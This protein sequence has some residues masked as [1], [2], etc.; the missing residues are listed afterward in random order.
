MRALISLVFALALTGSADAAARFWVGGTGTWDASDTTHWAASSGGA[1]GQSVPGS[2]DTV[3]FDGS[4]GG[5][6]VT[7]NH[8]SNTIQ[9]LTFGAFTGTLD[10]ATND[11]NITLTAGTGVSGTGTGARTLNMGDGTWTL[12]AT[13]AAWDFSTTTNL[14]FNANGSTIAYTSTAA[15]A[16]TFLSGGLTYNAVTVAGAASPGP[17]GINSSGNFTIGSLTINGPQAWGFGNTTT[18]TV[19]T[20]TVNASSASTLVSFLVTPFGSTTLT[21]TNAPT[22]AWCAFR[23]ITA[24]GGFSGIT[25]TDSQNLGGNTSFSITPPSSGGGGGSHVIGG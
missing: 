7:V 10:F 11:N 15:N 6:T 9:S 5:G 12:S 1:G 20:L 13:G 8:A 21:V 18:P 25:A 19:T 16:R 17:S 24:A 14:T 22:L 4:S 23:S 3:T 2:S